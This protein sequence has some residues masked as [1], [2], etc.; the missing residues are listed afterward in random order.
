MEAKQCDKCVRN[1]RMEVATRAI[2]CA[3]TNA[4]SEAVGYRIVRCV[5]SLWN[6]CEESR[7]ECNS[8]IGQTHGLDPHAWSSV[9]QDNNFCRE[10]GGE[11]GAMMER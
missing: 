7:F 4:G 10:N 5:I 8:A 2:P 3:A 1:L 11:V 6:G 9:V